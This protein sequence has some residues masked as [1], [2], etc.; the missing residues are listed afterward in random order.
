LNELQGDILKLFLLSIL[1]I[2]I[3]FA[4]NAKESA[5]KL[6]AENNYSTAI[7]KAKAEKKCL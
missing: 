4:G 7:K 5:L 1:F 2:S 6:G 3:S